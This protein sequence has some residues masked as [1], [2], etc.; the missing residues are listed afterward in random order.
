GLPTFLR[1]PSTPTSACLSRWVA[2]L[3]DRGPQHTL[4]YRRD[5]E[6]SR[7]TRRRMRADVREPI[8]REQ[9]LEERQRAFFLVRPLRMHVRL[10]DHHGRQLGCAPN[11]PCHITLSEVV[12]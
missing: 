5:Q 11:D 3:G 2:C 6:R 9:P 10:D 12:K 8:V 4:V 7:R 1:T